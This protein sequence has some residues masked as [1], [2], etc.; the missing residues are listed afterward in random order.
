M[1]FCLCSILSLFLIFPAIAEILD[2]EERLQL[3]DGL[4][5]RHMYE[6]AIKEYESFLREFPNSPKGDIIH[7]R[8]G[9]SYR[10][11]GN[12]STA[13]KEFQRVFTDYPNSEFRF[14]AGFR[15][16][17]LFMETRQYRD[18]VGLF[19]RLLKENPPEDITVACMYFQG[20]A[21]L[22]LGNTAEAVKAFGQIKDKYPSSRFYS[23]AL[24]KLGAF[25][26][27]EKGGEDKALEFYRMASEKPASDRVGAEALFQIAE[28]HFR[29]KVFDKSAEAYKEL[30]TKYPADQ[31]SAEARLQAAW[32]VHNAGLYAEAL[33][34]V[35]DSIKLKTTDTSGRSLSSKVPQGESK[36]EEW[37]YLKANCERQ[38]MKNSEAVQTYSDL[39]KRYP[40]CS[41]ADAA[42][43]EMALASYKMGKY[44][45]AIT[46]A[47]KIKLNLNIK[48]DVYWLL[49]ESYSA[50]KEQD[51]AIQYYRL[52]ITEFPKSDISCDATYRLA[53][54]LQTRGD[55]KEAS[56][57]YSIVAA[58]FPDSE[59][60]PQALFASA[61][62]L[63]KENMHVE[64]VRD[65]SMLI[66]KYPS[67]S[68]VEESL[69]QKAMNETGLGRNEE[70]M[71]SLQELVKR[72][73][74]SRFLADAHY[75]LG[76]LLSEA[77]RVEDA[78]EEFRVALK[79][80]P[81][82]ELARETEF[83]L[84]VVLQRRGKF[85][86]AAGLFQSLVS[87]PLRE[88]FSPA[89]LEWLSEYLFD[90]KKFRES[91]EAAQLL[92]ERSKELAWQQIGWCLVGRVHF[93]EGNTDAAQ[94]AFKKSLETG[95]A[96][97]FAAESALRLGDISL[98]ATNC[99]GC[100]EYFSEAARLASD[101]TMLGI[102]AHAYMGLAKAAKIGSDLESAARYF[103]SVAILYDDPEVVPEC[104][105]EAAEAFNKLENREAGEKAVAE[106]VVRY[107]ASEWAKKVAQQAKSVEVRGAEAPKQ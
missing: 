48:K 77:Q 66:R 86:E 75:W 85:D 28:L 93:A 107:P 60:A 1:K 41:F 71:A 57:H 84:A 92:I 82:K 16:A 58:D 73:T 103:M 27:G 52:L 102:R 36:E 98:A 53:H 19:I 5:A 54:H 3:A 69:Y 14:K 50:L 46:E 43:Y 4:Y 90:K 10:R 74:K 68:L 49:A 26:G 35:E 11:Q 80:T 40:E 56:R 18:A 101:E 100:A 79:S 76:V 24:L 30:L 39:L 72:F 23:H 45:E 61:F 44:T 29:R 32:A 63:A 21:F 22:N 55:Y 88:K 51:N 59:L 20:D 78:E 62:C 65:W 9:E 64:S 34:A 12:L 81:R 91:A 47:Q 83:R 17:E 15:R 95:A 25:Y 38:L 31:R 89:L 67:N 42:R 6:H 97:P 96:T 106:L 2:S 104:L 13:G 7:F 87:S 33:C 70:A 37:L 105:Y 94:K 8:I 99:Q